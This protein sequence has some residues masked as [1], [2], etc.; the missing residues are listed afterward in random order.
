MRLFVRDPVSL[1]RLHSDGVDSCM[2]TA[3]I[4]FNLDVSAAVDPPGIPVWTNHVVVNASGLVGKR[5]ESQTSIYVAMISALREVGLSV[6]L[7]PHVIRGGGDD[8]AALREIYSEFEADNNVFLI[9][10]LLSPYEVLGVVD[11]ARTIVSGRMHLSVLALLSGVPAVTVSTQGK[12]EG[13][14]D[15]FETRELFVSSDRSQLRRLCSDGAAMILRA[16]KLRFLVSRALP[17]VTADARKN[18]D[19]LEILESPAA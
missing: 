14:M 12:V 17:R 18:F 5:N 19:G 9:D 7:L 6:I 8:L 13:L 4:V 10:R 3:D 16:D 1:A 15:L 11:G 2:Q